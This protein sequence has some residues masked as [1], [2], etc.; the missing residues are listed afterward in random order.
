MA[1]YRFAAA[2]LLLAV[3]TASVAAAVDSGVAPVITAEEQHSRARKLASARELQGYRPI[4][5]D[6]SVVLLFM[7][8]VE[9]GDNSPCVQM[10]RRALEFKGRAINF[11]VTGYYADWNG[12]NK[13]EGLGYKES[14][15]D[16]SFKTYTWEA[17]NRYKA[18][19]T[20][21]AAG[22]RRSERACMQRARARPTAR[23]PHVCARRCCCP[24]RTAV[25]HAQGGR[26]QHVP[27][28]AHPSG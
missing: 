5:I 10:L 9:G 6:A 25:L 20:V 26:Q 18:G 8:D 2:L 14:Q 24:V 27:G 19:L 4:P 11:F 28:H 1:S 23:S 15:W 12:D 21:S 16:K 17:A 3:A 13:V 7:S 22:Q